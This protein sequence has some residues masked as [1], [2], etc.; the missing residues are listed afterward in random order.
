MAKLKKYLDP[1][2]AAL[3]GVPVAGMQNL[4]RWSEFPELLLRRGGNIHSLHLGGVLLDFGARGVFVYACPD[5]KALEEVDVGAHRSG[6]LRLAAG[7]ELYRGAEISYF[8]VRPTYDEVAAKTAEGPEG[9]YILRPE[10]LV[11]WCNVV[12]PC[13][14]FGFKGQMMSGVDSDYDSADGLNIQTGILISD[15]EMGSIA[16]G[17]SPSSFLDNNGLMNYLVAWRNVP[18]AHTLS[19]LIEQTP[20][21]EG[22]AKSR[23][24]LEAVLAD[25]PVDVK[26]DL[27]SA[28]SDELRNDMNLPVGVDVVYTR[29]NDRKHVGLGLRSYLKAHDRNG[30][31]DLIRP[32][33][34]GFRHQ[35]NDDP[36]DAPTIGAT[37]LTGLCIDTG[38]RVRS[39]AYGWGP[40][41]GVV[42]EPYMGYDLAD[43]VPRGFRV[44]QVEVD[45]KA[46][47]AD[48]CSGQQLQWIPTEF[49]DP[50]HAQEMPKLSDLTHST[51]SDGRGDMLTQVVTKE[52]LHAPDLLTIMSNAMA[53]AEARIGKLRVVHQRGTRMFEYSGAQNSPRNLMLVTAGTRAKDGL[54]MEGI[55]VRFTLGRDESATVTA[56]TSSYIGS[57]YN[58]YTVRKGGET[59]LEVVSVAD[60]ADP[61]ASTGG[62][63]G[64]LAVG[65]VVYGAAGTESK[66][67]GPH[68]LFEETN[69]GWKR[70]A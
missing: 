66:A 42:H 53:R 64:T 57:G 52:G 27:M 34:R 41:A 38:V 58:V 18:L 35:L 4:S 67:P 1:A 63:R 23:V 29:W 13:S 3:I 26:E 11:R 20:D 50:V 33:A 61:K 60:G 24:F 51:D 62:F 28:L 7:P 43:P 54:S 37:D 30:N 19:A 5:V 48:V 6:R 17:W 56:K 21:V 10:D 45:V 44:A 15:N 47:L 65:G 2:K 69:T 68:G 16:G 25:Y 39:E 31:G 8:H 14:M 22:L 40:A 59:L 55:K 46:F 9:N 70:V 12:T 36:G 49:T 32:A